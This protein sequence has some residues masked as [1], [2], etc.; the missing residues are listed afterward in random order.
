MSATT[1][2]ITA[3][4]DRW[5]IIA[6]LAYGDATLY[7]GIIKANPDVP[8]RAVLP[9]NIIINIPV[10]SG[11]VETPSNLPPWKR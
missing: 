11:A 2:Y 4:G 6:Y 10:I 3:E 8:I 5:D 1:R 7:Q 9:A